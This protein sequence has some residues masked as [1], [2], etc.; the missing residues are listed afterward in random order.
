MIARWWSQS[1]EERQE[2]AEL[3]RRASTELTPAQRELVRAGLAAIHQGI[4]GERFMRHAAWEAKWGR[5]F[6]ARRAALKAQEVEAAAGL[7]R[8]LKVV[9][10]R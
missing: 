7:R 2:I 5:I 4:E 8:E 1:A 10:G 3:R 9:E 6:E